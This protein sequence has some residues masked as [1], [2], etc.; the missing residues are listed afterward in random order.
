MIMLIS[1]LVRILKFNEVFCTVNQIETNQNTSKTFPLFFFRIERQQINKHLWIKLQFDIILRFKKN[2]I[3]K[4]YFCHFR[5]TSK[6]QLHMVCV[7]YNVNRT[8]PSLF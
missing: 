3:A 7:H 6:L 8:G 2:G 4:V 1:L 5:S